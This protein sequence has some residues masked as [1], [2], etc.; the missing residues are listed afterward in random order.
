MVVIEDREYGP[1]SDQETI[2]AIKERVYMYNE[3]IVYWYEVPVASVWQVQI[4]QQK[5]AELT[6]NLESFNIII[7]LSS[8]RP[9][10]MKVRATIKELFKAFH[11][12]LEKVGVFTE[13]NILVNLAAKFVL[14]D[15]GV[16]S[17]V[18]KTKDEALDFLNAN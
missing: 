2:E 8:A 9:P 4:F 12:K 16:P 13:K 1:D 5:I 3:N 17:D 15:L 18:V 10:S 11:G 7:D 6:Q 14:G